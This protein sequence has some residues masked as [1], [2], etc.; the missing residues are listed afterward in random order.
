MSFFSLTKKADYGLVLVCE[1]AKAGRGSVVSTELLSRTKK[2]PKP[3]LAGIGKDL[4]REKIIGSK[5]GKNGGYF[6]MRDPESIKVLE[7]IEAIE[8]KIK[9]VAC[10]VEDHGCPVEDSCIQRSF[11]LKFTLEIEQMMSRYMISNLINS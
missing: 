6:L 1:L 8:G 2:L 3:F 5:E 4:V 9:P 10:V 7:V 11:M